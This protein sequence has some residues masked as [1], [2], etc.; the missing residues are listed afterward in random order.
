MEGNYTMRLKVKEESNT[1]L[2]TRFVN[3]ESGRSMS[4]EHVITQIDNGNPNYKGYE[5]V[6]NPNGTVY[7]RSKPDGS[8]NNNIE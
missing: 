4:L 1:G 3:E 8:L 6:K 7:V 2:N 5:K